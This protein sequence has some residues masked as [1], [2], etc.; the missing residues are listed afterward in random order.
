MPTEAVGCGAGALLPQS[1]VFPGSALC[2]DS[3]LEKVQRGTLACEMELEDFS[4]TT[5]LPVQPLNFTEPQF[6]H[7]QNG[8]SHNSHLYGLWSGLNG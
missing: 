2:R 5:R 3:H 4:L 6:P 8:A 1:S 7:L